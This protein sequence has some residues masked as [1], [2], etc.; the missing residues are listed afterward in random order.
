MRFVQCIL[1]RNSRIP[2]N[3]LLFPYFFFDIRVNTPDHWFKRRSPFSLLS[4]KS[5]RP[6]NFWLRQFEIVGVGV[7]SLEML[8]LQMGRKCPQQKGQNSSQH[9]HF[10]N[11]GSQKLLSQPFCCHNWGKGVLVQKSVI[12]TWGVKL[13]WAWQGDDEFFFFLWVT[14]R[15]Q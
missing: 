2:L 15:D 10:Y 8:V 4:G 1:V 13:H 6:S 5:V 3:L 14:I 9:W 11:V 12:R 7:R